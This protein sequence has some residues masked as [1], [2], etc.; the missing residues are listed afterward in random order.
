MSLIVTCSASPEADTAERVVSG[1][2]APAPIEKLVEWITIC[3]VLTAQPREDDMTSE[4][5]LKAY[6]Q[7]LAR[8]PGD[9]VRHVLAEW[10]RRSKWFPAWAELQAALDKQLGYRPVLAEKVRAEL[11]GRA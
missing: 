5:K 1:L 11:R 8:Y 7:E 4:L 6:A 2:L 3:A 9:I 10:P